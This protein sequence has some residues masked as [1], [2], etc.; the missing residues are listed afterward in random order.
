M[1]DKKISALTGATT[2]LAGTE[3]LPIV[4]SGSTVK[5]SIADVTAGRDISAS[6]GTFTKAG[7]TQVTI[8][9]T[10]GTTKNTQLIFADNVGSKWRIGMDVFTNNNT[11]ELQVYSDTAGTS[12]FSIDT[13]SNVKLPVGNLIIGTAGKGI[14]FSA[15]PNPAGMTSE[16]L[17][18]YEEGTWTPSTAVNGFNGA[19]AITAIAGRYTKVG[20]LVSVEMSVTL[21][22]P[23]YP[24]TYSLF[25]GLPFLPAIE[26][27]GC[28]IGNNA[29]SGVQG[30]NNR[31][32]T[33]GQLWW[34]PSAS[35]VVSSNWTASINYF[36]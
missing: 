1:A 16:L 6:G 2:P 30:G 31:A 22:S 27:A 24:A 28:Y 3:V 5:V 26:A 23:S 12:P 7:V 20:R 13:S 17:N 9:N 33:S 11:N 10:T 25:T 15:N 4:Q 36:V 35:T 32:Y 21:A 8:A 14:D 19:P 34:W 18:D 29:G